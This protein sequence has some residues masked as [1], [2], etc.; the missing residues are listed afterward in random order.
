MSAYLDFMVEN[1]PERLHAPLKY[2]ALEGVARRYPVHSFMAKA[3]NRYLD[4]IDQQV[5]QTGTS[6]LVPQSESEGVKVNDQESDTFL[7]TPPTPI[8]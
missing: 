1:A 4:H 2:Q 7:N 5:E 8:D 6:D 3:I